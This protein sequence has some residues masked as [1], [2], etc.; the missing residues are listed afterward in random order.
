[1]GKTV[2]ELHEYDVALLFGQ[3]M[4]K[5]SSRDGG[6]ADSRGNI[7]DTIRVIIVE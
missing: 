4:P 5:A 3:F 7:P 1:M 2:Y 6:Q